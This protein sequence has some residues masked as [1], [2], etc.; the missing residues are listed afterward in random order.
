VPRQ[1]VTAL[2]EQ[3]SDAIQELFDQA[4]EL[5]GTP[6]EPPTPER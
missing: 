5:A 1:A 6:N 4:Q 3:L 2:T